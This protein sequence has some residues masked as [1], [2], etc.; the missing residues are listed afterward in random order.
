MDA[1]RALPS[2]IYGERFELAFIDADGVRC[3]EPLLTSWNTPFERCGQIRRF[4]SRRGQ[5]SFSG[6]WYFATSHEHVGYESWLEHDRLILLDADPDVVAVASQPFW[7]CWQDDEERPVRHAPD[8]FVRRRD[9]TAVVIDVRAD[10]RIGPK[11]AAKFTA[12]ARACESV[13]WGFERVGALDPVLA[14]NL[15]W[16]SGYRH[17][18]YHRPG[19]AE[20]LRRVFARPVPLM[21]GASEVGDPL[22]VLPTLFHMLWLRELQTDLRSS[23]LNETSL[24]RV[25]GEPR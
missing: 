5:R 11:D 21:E 24:I 7:L 14:T 6:L 3:R 4:T 2:A 16:L 18:R 23:P 25:A 20:Q 10:E 19:H 15:R 17:Q 1:A 9:G 12:T 8:Y 22:G 13:G